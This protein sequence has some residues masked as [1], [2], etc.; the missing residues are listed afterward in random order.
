GSQQVT[1]DAFGEAAVE[2][3]IPATAHLGP[4]SIRASMVDAGGASESVASTSVQLAAYKAAEFKVGVDSP[5]G[6]WTHGDEGRFDVHGNYLFGTP[7]AGATVRWTLTRGVG[8]FSPPGAEDLVTDDGAFARDLPDTSPR[9]AN[10]QSGTGALDAKGALST[11]AP[12][13]LP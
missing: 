10:F 2:L 11:H 9:A 4:A 1:L 13:T 8:W 7:M 12:L 5:P 3:A 6:V